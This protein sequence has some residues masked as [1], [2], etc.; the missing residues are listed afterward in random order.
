MGTFL[1]PLLLGFTFDSASAFTA[2]FSRRWGEERGQWATFVLR[3]VL[4]VPLWV[5]GLGLAVRSPSPMLF[6][7]PAL[8]EKV[9]WVLLAAGCGIQLLALTS[10]RGRAAKPSMADVLV[11]HG[12]Y[13]HIRH[14]IYAALLLEFV[15]LVLVKPRRTVALACALGILWAL[16][17]ARLEEVDLLQ[18]MPAYREYL[19]RVPRFMPRFRTQR[20]K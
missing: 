2:A 13:G 5:V 20:S 17:Q 9:G 3:N 14:P 19:A 10:L 18:R 16:V 7:P 4:G 11:E 8:L 6:V 12:V 15:A 1:I